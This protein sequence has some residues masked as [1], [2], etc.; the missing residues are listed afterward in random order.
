MR[1]TARLFVTSLGCALAALALGPLLQ[2]CANGLNQPMQLIHEV[3]PAYPQEAQ[4][5]GVEGWVRMRYDITAQ[6]LVANL[7]VA[8]AQPAGV[9][10]AAALQAVAQWRYRPVLVDGAPTAVVGV[11]STLRFALGG[12]QRYEGY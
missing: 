8:A 5:A 10:D 4:A 7:R 6:G 3:G 11:V 1:C 12:A 9:F 2:G